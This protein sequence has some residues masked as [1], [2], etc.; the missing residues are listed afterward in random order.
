MKVLQSYIYKL[1]CKIIDTLK[2]KTSFVCFDP[3]CIL[4][5]ISVFKLFL[6]SNKFLSFLFHFF[7]VHNKLILFTKRNCK[8]EAI[9]NWGKAQFLFLLRL[10]CTS[11][12]CPLTEITYSSQVARN[13]VNQDSGEEIQP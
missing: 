8:L 11:C 13:N 7:L 6:L 10:P 3:P 5:H 1:E 9:G 4:L 2:I 12:S